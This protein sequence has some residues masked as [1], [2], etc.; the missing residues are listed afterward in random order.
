MDRILTCV[1]CGYEYPQ[2]TESWGNE[3]L[4]EHIKQCEKHPMYKLRKALADLVG[5]S[6]REELEAMELALRAL[7]GI[8]QDKIHVI[9][10]IHVLLETC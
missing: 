10:A 3:V 8:E 4:T 6:T 2:G 9:N 7:P 1:Y 5:A